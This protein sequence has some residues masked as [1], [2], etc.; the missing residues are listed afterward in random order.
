MKKAVQTDLFERDGEFGPRNFSH[1]GTTRNKQR[2]FMRPLDPKYPIHLI[3]KS[4]IAVGKFSF[5]SETNKPA[6]ESIILANATKFN[7][8]IYDWANVGN[9]IHAFVKV[10]KRNDLRKFNR[11][12]AGQIAQ[13]VTGAKRGKPFGTYFWDYPPFTRIVHG[14]KGFHTML[15]YIRKNRVEAEFGKKARLAEEQGEVRLRRRDRNARD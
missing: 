13:R 10:V 3:F 11:A 7:I 15:N 14:R 12:T 5:L 1:G 2:K 6:I 4:E 8:K 9:H